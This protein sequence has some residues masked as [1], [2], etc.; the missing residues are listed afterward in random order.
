MSYLLDT[1]VISEVVKSNPDNNVLQWFKSVPNEAL[2]ISVLTLGEIRKGTEGVKDVKRK[3]KLLLWLEIELPRWFDGRVLNIDLHVADR[4]GRLQSEMKKPIPAIDS[5]LAATAI[6]HDLR[7]VTRNVK[8][9][10]F[11]A[12]HVICPWNT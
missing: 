7:L 1:N 6:Q 10:K 9:F 8:D 11:P 3:E 12:L 5:L 4:W 2:F